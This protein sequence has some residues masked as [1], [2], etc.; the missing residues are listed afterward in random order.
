MFSETVMKRFALGL[1]CL[2]GVVLL[3]LDD[4]EGQ[5]LL[6]ATVVGW[7]VIWLVLESTRDDG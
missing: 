6:L 1:V 5:A 7:L 4:T 3:A 2:I